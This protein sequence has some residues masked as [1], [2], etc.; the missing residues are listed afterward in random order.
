[1]GLE[2]F[3]QCYKWPGLYL[4]QVFEQ[5]LLARI[6]FLVCLTTVFEIERCLKYRL[7]KPFLACGY[8]CPSIFHLLRFAHQL[9]FLTSVFQVKTI[10]S[11]VASSKCCNVIQWRIRGSLRRAINLKSLFNFNTNMQLDFSTN[12]PRFALLYNYHACDQAICTLFTTPS[13]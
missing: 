13:Y 6:L 2:S 12:F 3:S 8:S 11:T 7:V 4:Q 5:N 1:M 9:T 10:L